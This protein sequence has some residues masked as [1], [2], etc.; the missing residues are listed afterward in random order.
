MRITKKYAGAA[1]LGRRV[2]QF[3][4]RPQPSV[5]EIQ[6]AKAE[7]D[8]LEQRFRLRVEE[9]RPGMPLP[10]PDLGVPFFASPNPV[11][12]STQ[13]ALQ[14]LLINAASAGATGLSLPV[15]NTPAVAP[16]SLHASLLSQPG[17]K[18]SLGEATLGSV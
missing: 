13:A 8:L 3:R 15:S 14:S 16:A 4:D 12:L 17:S 9:G 6:L 11:Q 1:G 2:Y 7:L 10:R 5:A 18:S